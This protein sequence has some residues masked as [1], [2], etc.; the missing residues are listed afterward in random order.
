MSF[1]ELSVLPELISAMQKIAIIAPTE[2]QE[3]SIV[4]I[5][6]NSSIAMKSQTGTGKT[7]AYLLPLFAKI[8]FGEKDDLIVILAPTH[9]L[10]SQINSVAGEL[11][12]SAGLSIKSMLLIGSTNISR[13]IENLKKK[14]NI[15]VGSPGRINEL[16]L[17]KKIKAHK[18]KTIV[19]DEAD[20]LLTDESFSVIKA[21][22]KSLQKDVQMIFVSA[23]LNDETLQ[24]AGSLTENIISV[25]VDKTKMPENIEHIFFYTDDE[26]EKFKILR[27]AI[28]ALNINKALLFVSKNEDAQKICERLVFH[29]ISAADFHGLKNKLERQKVITDFRKGDIQIL[30]VSDIAARG[31]DIEGL[32]QVINYNLSDDESQYLHRAGRT[33]RAEKRGMAVTIAAG[34]EKKFLQAIAEKNGII[35]HQ[36]ILREGNIADKMDDK[37]L[38]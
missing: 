37:P 18:I 29:G 6:K 8:T 4:E 15:L 24:I 17:Q 7:L 9:E 31:L 23:T 13:Q 38:V 36:K 5:S 33:G 28:N 22:R 27:K 12:A 16:I 30:V 35:L 26:R 3:L 34:R 2:I 20:R 10:A 14:P 32:T 19:I 1:E 25:S 21:I 11:S